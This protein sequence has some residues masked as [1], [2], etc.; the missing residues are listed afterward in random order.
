MKMFNLIGFGE[1]AGSGVP[2]IYSTW[3]KAGYVEPIV[4]EQFGGGL[5]NRTI[6]ILPL[7]EKNQH[8]NQ[9]HNQHQGSNSGSD[10]GADPVDW[11]V[12]KKRVMECLRMNP[13]ISRTKIA[14]ETG[15]TKRQAERVIDRL[16]N[17]G[18][19]HRDGPAHGGNW[20]VDE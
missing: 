11:E 10:Y 5:P 3:E 9:H 6:V 18:I 20:V 17:E 1:R 14:K 16:K 13:K 12:R 4:E 8:P 2:D 19:I 15:L 7:I